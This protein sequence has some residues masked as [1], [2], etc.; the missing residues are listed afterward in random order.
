[1]M[2]I[3][4]T[5]L[6]KAKSLLFLYSALLFTASQSFAQNKKI[7]VTDVKRREVQR[8]YGLNPKSSFLSRISTTPPD[9]IQ[10]FRDAGMSPTEHQITREET[11]IIA[12]AFAALPPLHQQVLKQHLKS[13]SFLDNMPNTALTS[14]VTKEEGINLYHITFRAGILHQTISEWATGKEST[15][16]AGGDS[17]IT[18]SIKAGM[19]NALMYVMLHEGTHV[20]DGSLQLL[21]ADTVAGHP[22]SNAF[23]KSFAQGIWKDITTLEWPLTDSIAVKSRFRN[24]GRRFLTSEATKVYTSLSQTQFTS[25]YSTASWNEDLAEMLTVYHLTQI[26][27][28]PFRFVVKQ[29]GKEIFSYEPMG[30]ALVKKRTGVLKF[31]YTL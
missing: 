27:K 15:C 19:L 17:S 13:V 14:P 9:I 26:F 18:V 22:A 3:T 7:P 12:A 2:R 1:M 24:G 20:V 29:Y 25:L 28:Q 21:S 5:I 10:Q 31:F 4:L 11:N 30:S 6:S 8:A 16:F 23:T